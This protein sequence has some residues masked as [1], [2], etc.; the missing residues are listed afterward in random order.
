MNYYRDVTND[1]ENEIDDNDNKINNNKTTRSK[2]FNYKTTLIG[3][4]PNNNSRLNVVVVVP[5]KYFSNFCRSLDFGDLLSISIQVLF[6]KQSKVSVNCEIELDWKW[7]RNCV[8]SEVSRIFRAVDPNADPIVYEVATQTITVTFQMNNAKLYVPVVTFSITDN[9]KCLE[10][11]KQGFKKTL[12]WNKYRSEITQTRNNNLDYLIDPNFR[13][14]NMIKPL[15][16]L[17]DCFYIY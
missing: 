13:N 4:T 1:D 3:S 7:T 16:I 2:S 5:L 9:I 12:S 17:I 15:E 10:N 14:I 11:I 8:T 6:H